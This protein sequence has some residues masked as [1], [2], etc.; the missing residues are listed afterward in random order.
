MTN[1]NYVI[2]KII[3]EISGKNDITNETDVIRENY[4]KNE[5]TLNKKIE[6]INHKLSSTFNTKEY[7]SILIS[8]LGSFEKFKKL[9]NYE[10]KILQMEVET[11]S[12][13]DYNLKT[14][15]HKSVNEG[16]H[17]Y[18]LFPE[19]F[20][21]FKESFNLLIKGPETQ[22]GYSYRPTYKLMKYY[23][24]LIELLINDNYSLSFIKEMTEEDSQIVF[25]EYLTPEIIFDSFCVVCLKHARDNMFTQSDNTYDE[26]SM[27][28]I[29]HNVIYK[30][31][32]HFSIISITYS[33][34]YMIRK[35]KKVIPV[36]SLLRSIR[37]YIIYNNVKVSSLKGHDLF[38]DGVESMF[39]V[40]VNSGIFSNVIVEKSGKKDIIKYSFPILLNNQLGRFNLPPRVYKPEKITEKNLQTYIIPSSFSRMTITSE[41]NL[42]DSLNISNGKRFSVNRNF[43]DILDYLENHPDLNINRPIP[44]L[45]DINMCEMKLESYKIDINKFDSLFIDSIQEAISKR[46]LKLKTT[47]QYRYIV[48][49]T[50]AEQK[51]ILDKTVLKQYLQELKITRGG[52]ITRLN[53]S[54]ILENF[55]LYFTNKLC[56]TGRPFAHEY[57]LSRHIGCLKLLRGEYTPT[58]VSVKGIIHMMR[59]YYSDD[60]S[61]YCQF[62]KFLNDSK[63][64]N[65]SILQEFYDSNRIDYSKKEAVTHFMLLSIE[66]K[67]VFC[68]KKSKLLLQ[69]DQVASGLV[70]IAALFRNKALAIQTNLHY[71]EGASSSPYQYAMEQF[72]T[73]YEKNIKNKNEK[74]LVLGKTSRKLHKYAMMCYSYNQSTYG[75]TQDFVTRWVNEFGYTP[76]SEEWESLQEVS[77]K[78]SDFINKLFPG[79]NTQIRLLNDIVE[80]VVKDSGSLRIRALDGAIIEWKFFKMKKSGRNSFDPHTLIPKSYSLNRVSIDKKGNPEYDL[81]QFKVKFLSYLVH[82]FDAGVM[83]LIINL[84]HKKHKY[85]V[86]QLFDCILLHPNQVDNFYVIL[87]EIYSLDI[88]HDYLSTNVFKVW[89]ESISLD[90]HAIFDEKVLEFRKICDKCDVKK[91]NSNLSK[92]YTYEV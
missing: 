36:D 26:K 29:R 86:D 28:I 92:M 48:D 83:R 85:R 88:F 46:N 72:E 71:I 27:T 1:V 13:D 2:H 32:M 61:L 44:S 18:K 73:F 54:K 63:K 24:E 77:S 47:F 30:I 60:K 69:I 10:K 50:V 21:S 78:Y 52:G 39:Q 90:K 20:L 76:N 87:E 82:S 23:S 67:R 51:C 57:I 42:L 68:G 11:L 25:K 16:N 58:K 38:I 75:R 55:P 15:L 4:K 79:L 56:N 74:V 91:F 3:Q 37:N 7:E 70:F 89:R 81:Q 49:M 62:N 43:V 35:N 53:H 17:L 65:I 80:I 14:Y 34:Q 84:M 19:V 5:L 9:S 22:R 31:Y 33:I 8:T 59:S 64:L 66:L 41:K 12:Y 40:F 6:R 45:Y